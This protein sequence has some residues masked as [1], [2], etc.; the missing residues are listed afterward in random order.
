VATPITTIAPVWARS[1]IITHILSDKKRGTMC[2]ML[3]CK[4]CDK[5]VGYFHPRCQHLVQDHTCTSATASPSPATY[6]PRST[7]LLLAHHK[8]TFRR[9]SAIP[10]RT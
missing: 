3:P 6:N 9:C 1:P 10:P 4:G 5:A 7:K 8:D 2:L